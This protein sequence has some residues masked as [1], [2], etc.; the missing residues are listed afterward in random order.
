MSSIIEADRALK[1]KQY[2]LSVNLYRALAQG[3]PDNPLIYQGLAQG[4]LRVKAYDDAKEASVKALEL[5]PSLFLPYIVMAYASYA[6]GDLDTFRTNAKM[7]FELNPNSAEV[8][9]CLGIM[10]LVDNDVE[11]GIETLNKA[12]QID[13]SDIVASRN[14]EFAYFQKGDYKNA[15]IQSKKIFTA[16]PTVK[17]AFHLLS[18]YHNAHTRLVGILLVLLGLLAI[19]LRTVYLVIPYLPYAVFGFWAGIR[20][21]LMGKW[22]NGVFSFVYSAVIMV[23][24][25]AIYLA[26]R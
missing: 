13:P 4:L 19:S 18:A 7:A 16:S 17:S 9:T 24:L 22:K 26:T 25:Y 14:L 15:L 3:E 5:S 8:L 1:N 21:M 12:L 2:R 11:K 6:M 20:F 23:I 10:F